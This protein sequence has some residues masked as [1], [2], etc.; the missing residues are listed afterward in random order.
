MANILIFSFPYWGHTQQLLKIA[1]YLAAN[2]HR[3]YLDISKE[4]S[5]QADRAVTCLNCRFMQNRTA[6]EPMDN[7][8]ALYYYADGVMRCCIEYLSHLDTYR[9]LQPNL[10]LY[11]T[12]AVWGKEI[13]KSLR[14]PYIASVTMQ[15]YILEHWI[16]GQFGKTSKQIKRIR[17]YERI[18]R[19]KYYQFGFVT[20][21]EMIYAKGMQNIVYTSR[22]MCMHVNELDDTYIFVGAMTDLSEKKMSVT[23]KEENCKNI[24][25]S[26]GTILDKPVL[27]G[28]CIEA[29][30]DMPYTLYVSAG[31]SAELLN[32]QYRS[33][34][35]HIQSRQPQSKLL[36]SAAL[37]ITHA[38]HNSMIESVFYRVPMLALPQVNDE[39]G[40]ANM[41]EEMGLGKRLRVP[42][43][44]EKIRKAALQIL[45]DIQIKQRLEK[46]AKSLQVKDP[47]YKI[48]EAIEDQ[49]VERSVV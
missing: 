34:H 14:I 49:L 48:L 33:S 25:I 32:R 17:M 2:G 42:I 1:R 24:L 29:L 22:D 43:T 11:D 28:Q 8:D 18:L 3:V 19:M 31:Q 27:I 7:E 37:F 20:L 4:Y 5:T 9:R 45:E 41:I 40:N 15:P 46:T 16:H 30:W 26:F 35:I 36:Q 10:I 12:S 39:F 13:A 44:T 47:L 38:G 23:E 6:I 21:S